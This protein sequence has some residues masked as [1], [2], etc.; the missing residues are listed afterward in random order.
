[1]SSTV[2]KS[3][4]TG[5]RKIMRDI[6]NK[7]SY[8][9][10][11]NI[12]RDATS[13][14]SNPPTP[15]QLAKISHTLQYHENYD[16]MFAMIWRRLCHLEYKRHVCKS[17]L[18]LDYLIRL[19]PPSL[20]IQLRLIVDVRERWHEIW[21]LAKLRTE[22]SSDTIRQIQRVAERLCDWIMRYEQG[23]WRLE[24]EETDSYQENEEN[25]KRK[26]K[27]KTTGGKK[28]KKKSKPVSPSTE[29]EEEEE[30]E[31]D[32]MEEG[33]DGDDGRDGEDE[34][35][36]R[37]AQY[38]V[39]NEEDEKHKSHRRHRSTNTDHNNNNNNNQNSEKL[40]V[41]PFGF[42]FFDFDKN[43]NLEFQPPPPQQQPFNQPFPFQ[44]PN[45]NMNS[46]ICERC[47]YEN[48][49]DR[50]DCEICSTP[51][52]SNNPPPNSQSVPIAQPLSN[53]NNSSNFTWNNDINA[54]NQNNNSNSN[55]NNGLQQ[56]SGW[57]CPFCSFL[58]KSTAKVCEVCEHGIEEH[59]D[60]HKH[61]DTAD[62]SDQK[63]GGNN[64]NNSNN[65]HNHNSN[66]AVSPAGNPFL[67]PPSL[68]P[69]SKSPRAESSVKK[70]LGATI[71]PAASATLLP[72]A[73]VS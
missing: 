2:T 62:Y 38:Q 56:Q 45:S 51:R 66:S 64:N 68:T 29:E 35:K 11:E 53:Q 1:M 41:S 52:Y 3:A 44:L 63:E 5:A 4:T 28:H 33:E 36:H 67:S 54:M 43:I 39:D 21:R 8:E 34:S 20:A 16:K 12:V 59:P 24:E 46:W 17:L 31:S 19:K 25:N 49:L 57:N 10:V 26:K 48:S 60:T 65:N 72:G 27:K 7:F 47:T 15:A 9:E 61:F 22:S 50:L 13:N 32:E 40:A 69:A 14:T 73:W 37:N 55:T 6:R 58:N 30:T 23:E 71:N 42:D 70:G 18:V